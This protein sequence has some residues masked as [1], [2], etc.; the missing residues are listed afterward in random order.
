[1]SKSD[2]ALVAL[3]LALVGA[4]AWFWL[5]RGQ[6][7]PPP[8]APV[9]ATP[10]PAQ[11]APPA[12]TP[13]PDPP[14]A[15]VTDDQRRALLEGIT[16]SG[17]LRRWLTDADALERWAV[18]TDNLAEGAS[19]RRALAF[20][21]PAKP[22]A[23][24]DRGGAVVIAPESYR[25]YDAFAEAVAGLDAQAVARAYRGLHG[26]AQA[27]YRALGYPGAS[28]DEVTARALRRLA[29]APVV[30]REIVLVPAPEGAIWLHADPKLEQ[31][32]AVEK[33]LL[34]MGPRNQKLVQA[35][36]RELLGALGMAAR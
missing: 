8:P 16:S 10:A 11:P 6:P 3:A 22:F 26:V 12:A 23:V 21:E 28:L 1:M 20:L 14:A 19:P 34:R 2:W 25:R 32:S 13:A 36:A 24:A 30:E 33:H 18:V 27:A 9:A 35:K 29:A 4:G 15:A 5:G 7:A 31:L 17:L